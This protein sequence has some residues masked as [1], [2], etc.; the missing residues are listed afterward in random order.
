MGNLLFHP[1]AGQSC[2]ETGEGQLAEHPVSP[3]ETVGPGEFPHVFPMCFMHFTAHLPCRSKA[4][5]QVQLFHT[6][7][8]TPGW[9]Q[10][11]SLRF[12]TWNTAQCYFGMWPDRGSPQGLRDDNCS[13]CD[14][15]PGPSKCQRGFVSL[16]WQAGTTQELTPSLNTTTKPCLKSH[17]PYFT[18]GGATSSGTSWMNW[19]SRQDDAKDSQFGRKG[20]PLLCWLDTVGDINT[21]FWPL[22]QSQPAGLKTRLK[23]NAGLFYETKLS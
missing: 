10:P 14:W 22:R 9:L 6:E 19:F 21:S 17:G 1:Q 4:L 2:C 11:Q 15:L 5:E 12:F 3:K 23:E 7:S 13:S 18:W 8:H 16:Y 20:K